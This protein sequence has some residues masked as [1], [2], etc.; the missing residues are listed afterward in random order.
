M[1]EPLR[2]RVTD[3]DRGANTSLLAWLRAEDELRGRVELEAA[4]PHPGSLGTLAD[5]LTVA[6]GA[7]G[8]VSGLTSALIAWIRRRAGETV[9]Q[10]TLADGS[11]VELRA[12]AV[13]GP[14]DPVVLGEA[15]TAAAESA[16]SLRTARVLRRPRPG[17]RR[18]RAVPGDSRHRPPHPRPRLQGAAL[19]HPAP[20]AG[21]LPRRPEAVQ[22]PVQ[23]GQ[24]AAHQQGPGRALD[25]TG[26]G[27]WESGGAE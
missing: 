19:R 3:A 7:G 25:P 15:L 2:I 27:R 8:A 23:P 17:R 21:R 6:V 5:V 13:H 22:P 26:R 16:D 20:D 9:V 14:E 12:T 1:G 24:P 18:Q 4:P 11:S 10:V